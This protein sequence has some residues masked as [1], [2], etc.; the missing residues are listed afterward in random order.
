[1]IQAANVRRK[2]TD[3]I[4]TLY[5][6]D[7][8]VGCHGFGGPSCGGLRRGKEPVSPTIWPI[9]MAAVQQIGGKRIYA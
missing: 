2:D 3:L 6:M 4:L 8:Q 1:M 5:L 7:V 9:G